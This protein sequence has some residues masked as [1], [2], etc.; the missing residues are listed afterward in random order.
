[1]G[2]SFSL[3]SRARDIY[4]KISRK[5]KRVQRPEDD[6]ESDSEPAIKRL[7]SGVDIES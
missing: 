2:I 4:E 6:D 5:R 3:F 7:D 1:M